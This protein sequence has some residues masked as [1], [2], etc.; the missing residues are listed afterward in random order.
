MYAAIGDDKSRQVTV[1]NEKT[2]READL[3]ADTAAAATGDG[4]SDGGGRQVRTHGRLFTQFVG[5][6]LG[7]RVL[8]RRVHQIVGDLLWGW[9]GGGGWG[10]ARGG[11]GE[12]GREGK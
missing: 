2:A 6:L 7:S 4:G 3:R 8:S 11:A 1:S 12:V 9:V 5:A 10:S